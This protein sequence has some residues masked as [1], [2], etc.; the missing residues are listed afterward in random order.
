MMT[1]FRSCQQQYCDGP[2]VS[3]APVSVS[4]YGAYFH[5]NSANS[6]ASQLY[7][8]VDGQYAAVAQFAPT[9]ASQFYHHHQQQQQQQQQQ[10]GYSTNLRSYATYDLDST[11]AAAAATTT[12][13]SNSSFYRIIQLFNQLIHLIYIF[14]HH[15]FHHPS[16]NHHLNIVQKKFFS[17]MPIISIYQHHNYKHRLSLIFHHRVQLA[18]HQALA[19]DL[20]RVIHVMNN[21]I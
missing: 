16:Y 1:D 7:S 8:S 4:S 3:T 10:H 13:N 11:S 17:I 5:P 12:T 21:P 6:S 2:S 18:H 9:Y 15:H 19:L 20:H 14:E